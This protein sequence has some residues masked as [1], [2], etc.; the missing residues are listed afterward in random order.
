MADA[1]DRARFAAHLAT[2]RLGRTLIARAEVESTNDVAWDALMQDAPDGTTVVADVQTRGRGRQGRGW[3]TAPGRGLAL[4]IALVQ[5][6]ERLQIGVLPLVAGLALARGLD[7]LGVATRL[8]WPND[9][10]AGATGRKLSGILCESRRL[11][12][13]D[14]A[15][16]IGVG[17]NVSQSDEDFPTE[18]RVTATSL[19]I[20]GRAADRETVAAAFL[21]ALEPLWHVVQ[22]GGREP[23]IAAWKE[24]AAFWGEAVTVR[25]PSGPVTGVA[26]DLD[27]S[28]ALV[29]E[30]AGGRRVTVWAGDLEAGP[31]E[32][33]R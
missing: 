4:S 30:L 28:G 15:A 10:L 33:R 20:E 17:V 26:R 8:K 27:P 32:G 12:N 9:L 25:T 1:F 23:V 5:G 6:C 31:V 29:L 16:V 18:L 3:H 21:N 11:A 22:E 14:D 2:R 7:G 19:A 24:R 13:G